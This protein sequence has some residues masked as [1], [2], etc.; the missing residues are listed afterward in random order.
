M[1]TLRVQ[2]FAGFDIQHWTFAQHIPSRRHAGIETA[3]LGALQTVF[4]LKHQ[5]KVAEARALLSW[6][7]GSENVAAIK[8]KAELKCDLTCRNALDCIYGVLDPVKAAGDKGLII[9]LV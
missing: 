8:K 3:N 9:L 1:L 4:A 2:L 5:V 6:L 7:S